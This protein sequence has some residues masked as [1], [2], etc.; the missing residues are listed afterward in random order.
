MYTRLESQKY[1]K[2]R[3]MFLC[4]PST[5]VSGQY[6]A[7]AAAAPT[8]GG[9]AQAVHDAV[10]IVVYSRALLRHR[11]QGVRVKVTAACGFQIS[12]NRK[13]LL[14]APLPEV[15]LNL[16]LTPQLMLHAVLQHEVLVH[17]LV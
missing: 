4:L 11:P 3:R 1:P 2:S 7:A 17:H 8:D 13:G 6:V 15:R 5:R 10:V 14:F 16:D 12:S 9:I